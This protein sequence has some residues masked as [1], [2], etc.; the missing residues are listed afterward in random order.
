MLHGGH[1]V[2]QTS[3]IDVDDKIFLMTKASSSSKQFDSK[4][5]DVQNLGK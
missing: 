4:L 5:F 3:L 1:N 2:L